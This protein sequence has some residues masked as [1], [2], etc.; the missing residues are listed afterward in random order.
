MGKRC[1]FGVVLIYDSFPTW[2]QASLAHLLAPIY[3]YPMQSLKPR[4]SVSMRI[5]ARKADADKYEKLGRLHKHVLL[6]LQSDRSDDI[7]LRAERRIQMWE[8]R[9][10]CSRFYI[11]SWRRLINSNPS[12]IEREV[13]GD[14]PQAHALAQNSPFSFLMKEVR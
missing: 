1:S 3:T 8:E 4:P 11:D 5:L 2:I 10:L 9:E 12:E 7:K 14:A 6:L 13:C